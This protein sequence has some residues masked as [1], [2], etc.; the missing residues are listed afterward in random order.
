MYW[1]A[2]NREWVTLKNLEEDIFPQVLSRHLIE[3]LE[4]LQRRSLIEV[5]ISGFTQQ[6][7]V[8]EYITEQI[9]DLRSTRDYY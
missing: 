1:L 7:V 4:S 6:P 5:S 3:A 2:I 9:I 8:M